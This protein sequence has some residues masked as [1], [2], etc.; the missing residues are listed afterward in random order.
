MS[1]VTEDFPIDGGN[2][3]DI[4]VETDYQDTS[5][6]RTV[7]QRGGTDERRVAIYELVRERARIAAREQVAKERAELD[8][9]GPAM[10]VADIDDMPHSLLG[11]RA[12]IDQEEI[13]EAMKT[14][15]ISLVDALKMARKAKATPT[16]LTLIGDAGALLYRGKSN[17]LSGES[18]EGKSMVAKLAV[19]QEARAGRASL[20]I[21]RE[22][23]ITEFAEKVFELGDV[24]N[25]EAALIFYWSPERSTAALMPM[26]LGFAKKYDID[27]VVYDSVSRDMSAFS[28]TA[29]ENS[30]DDVRRWYTACVQPVVR[31]GRTPFLIDHVVKPPTSQYGKSVVSDSLYSKGAVAKREVL[32]GHAMMMRGVRSFS[33]AKGGWAKLIDA[34]DNTGTFARGQVVAEFHVTP[35][36]A[37]STFELRPNNQPVDST[38]DVVPT[39]L[40]EKLSRFIEE[41]DGRPSKNQVLTGVGG[42]SAAKMN[43]LGRLVDGG[44]L[45]IED[46]PRA[47]KLM[48]S[49]RPFRR[50]N[51]EA[52]ARAPARPPAGPTADDPPFG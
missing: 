52:A 5:R 15:P 23:D 49:L 32:T 20:T 16:M 17:S 26:I 47:A 10:V 33:Q 51:F 24:T 48:V 40:M 41:F 21:D 13:E 39:I 25:E 2:P 30:N 34:K 9:K 11:E 46:G 38:G 6:L 4:P 19:L 14:R 28:D 42:N 12:E 18:G 7:K 8:A 22:K 35:G 36:D 50:E 43:G 1:D 27:L 37:R 44:Y 3:F 29:S 31:L 45:R